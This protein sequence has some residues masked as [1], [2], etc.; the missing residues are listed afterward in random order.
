MLLWNVL[1]RLNINYKDPA[2]LIIP[3][4]A[5]LQESDKIFMAHIK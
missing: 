5:T 1:S 4:Y 2:A 3:W